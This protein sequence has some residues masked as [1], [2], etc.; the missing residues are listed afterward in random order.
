MSG[1]P[2]TAGGTDTS[3]GYSRELV[4]YFLVSAVLSLGYGSV[5]TLLGEIRDRFGLS[6]AQVGVIAGAGFLAGFVAQ[7]GLARYADRGHAALI[8]RTGI[9]L[10]IVGVG[11]CTVADTFF[12][13]VLARVTLGLGSGMVGPAV[14][15]V[16]IAKDPERVG[17]NLGMQGAFDVAGFVVG[18][19]L[20][21]VLAEVVAFRSPFVVLAVVYLGLG[22]WVMR[23]D[24]SAGEVAAGRRSVRSL[25][26]LPAMQA[27]L[28]ASIAFY[29]TIGMFE[30]VWSPMLK[31]LGARPWLIGVSF[32]LF[33]IPM[34][35]LAPMGGKLAQR[36][37]PMNVVVFSILVAT[38]CT[39]SYG[40]FPLWVLLLISLVHACADSFTMPGNQIAVAM[41]S[42][43]DQL[44][45]GQGLLGS[46]GLL[47]A[48]LMGVAG[49]SIYGALGRRWLFTLTAAAM[50]VFLVLAWWRAR[51]QP[52]SPAS[53]A[54]P[55]HS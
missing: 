31:D 18:P 22:L 37:G 55:A 21:G 54:T 7:T 2:P 53:S 13:W 16:V 52:S 8:V 30:A 36:R 39:A 4:P 35:V 10:A 47:V 25:L 12:L 29:I 28:F 20:A 45:A 11:L 41:S 38:V 9:V 40:F 6:D 46:V 27:A 48:G 34:V 17:A 32:S 24:L 44:A 19:V 42:P 3:P 15:R 43:P 23:L 49:G 33:T 50:A 1:A 51:A 14:R 5:L 26:K